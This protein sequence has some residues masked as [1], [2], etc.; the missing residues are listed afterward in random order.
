MSKD[1]FYFPHYCN[2]R[3]DR[4]IKR[5]VKEF[6][7][8]GY[9]IYFMLLEVLREQSDLKFPM[10]DIDLLADEFGTSE[11]KVRTIVCNYKLFE[12]DEEEQFFSPKMLVFLRPYFKMKEQR[13]DASMAAKRKRELSD[14]RPTGDRPDTDR[15]PTGHRPDTDR[16]P[17]GDQRKESKEK[18]EKKEKEINT[19]PLTPSP[20]DKGVYERF[21]QAYP[22]NMSA[23]NPECEIELKEALKYDAAETIIAGT[24]AYARYCLFRYGENQMVGF[25]SQADNFLR[26]RKYREDWD[27]KLNAERNVAMKNASGKNS[28][29][30]FDGTNQS[31][32]DNLNY[33]VVTSE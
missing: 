20:W 26:K 27:A 13:M 29:I 21:K 10:E 18:K 9:G 25:I 23:I 6:G 11:P 24:Y 8:E 22:P 32:Y 12:I 7:L 31:K 5:L 28:T 2:A 16:T 4:K 14:R 3:H 15:R 17:T 19:L 1:A 30:V 33:E